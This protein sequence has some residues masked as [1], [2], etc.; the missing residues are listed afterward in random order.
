M[1]VVLKKQNPIHTPAIERKGEQSV[2][3]GVLYNANK[4]LTIAPTLRMTKPENAGEDKNSIVI[5]F[6]FKF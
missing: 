4:G 2:I 5:N 3:A 6:Q 1:V